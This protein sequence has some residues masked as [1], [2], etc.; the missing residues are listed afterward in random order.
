MP[1]ACQG[2]VGGSGGVRAG[3]DHCVKVDPDFA[4]VGGR[5]A[6]RVRA[7]VRVRAGE[8]VRGSR[9]LIEKREDDI[10]KRAFYIRVESF[11][12]IGYK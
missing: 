8:D 4:N 6:D 5:L 12:F 3:E 9:L 2:S 7:R 1:P 10:F 11:F